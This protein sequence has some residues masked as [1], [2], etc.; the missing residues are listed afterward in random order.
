MLWALTQN[1]EGREWLL[2]GGGP[3]VEMASLSIKLVAVRQGCR[4]G[5]QGTVLSNG[6]PGRG[7]SVCLQCNS[8]TGLAITGYTTL[9]RG[10][11]EDFGLVWY[12]ACCVVGGGG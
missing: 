4:D 10:K 6:N 1:T 7:R 8:V 5:R 11:Q 2:D 9:L 3:D 12:E